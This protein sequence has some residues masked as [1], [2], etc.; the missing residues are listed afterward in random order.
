MK[1]LFPR[2]TSLVSYRSINLFSFSAKLLRKRYQYLL[3]PAL[4]ILPA[5]KPSG[6]APSLPNPVP[7][8]ATNGL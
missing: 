6:V 7:G 4:L 1:I 3:F 2:L 8:K 5:V